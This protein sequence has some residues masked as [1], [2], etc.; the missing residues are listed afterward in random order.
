MN[1]VNLHLH[2][3]W[4]VLDAVIKP[5]EL[6][7]KLLE[8]GQDTCAVT[9]HGSVGAWYDIN[10]AFSERGI[11]P[12]FGCEFYCRDSYNGEKSKERKHLICLA[13]NQQGLYNIRKLN[14]I[15]NDNFYYK[16]IMS[17]ETLWDNCD[18]LVITS[19]CS[20]GS[21]AQEILNNNYNKAEDLAIKFK[22]KI[23]DYYL[24][25]QMHPDYH[26]Q[27]KV[28]EQVIKISENTGI[29][30]VVTSD[31]HFINVEDK[32]VR[33]IIEAIGYHQKIE[34]VYQSLKSNSLGNC[35]KISQWALESGFQHD[36]ILKK[37]FDN[38]VKVG[39]LCNA[40]LEEPEV[41]IPVFN[42]YKELDSLFDEDW[43]C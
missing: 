38:T 25:L 23:D 27:A 11:K 9:D 30:T 18:G 41:R 13:K 26:D 39:K 31:S 16:P 29:D 42:R 15:A 32:Y 28:N 4:S 2:T 21:V 17:Y 8:Y 35:D 37:S 19:A 7:D 22:D 6:G 12:I 10:D 24:E 5:N 43:W 14:K 34:D 33:N 20:L 40:K 3:T 1:F 36:D